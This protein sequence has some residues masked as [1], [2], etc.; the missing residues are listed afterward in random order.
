MFKY[1]PMITATIAF[2]F[3][4]KQFEGAIG[5]Y[6]QAIGLNPMVATYYGNRSIAYLKTESYGYALAD[7]TK[8]IELD[9]LYIKVINTS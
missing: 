5:L 6:T 8:S 7:A 3:V 2:N 9:K 4:D 1:K